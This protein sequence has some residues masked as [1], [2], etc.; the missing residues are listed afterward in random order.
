MSPMLHTALFLL[1]GTQAY[2]AFELCGELQQ[3]IA[4]PPANISSALARTLVLV[5]SGGEMHQRRVR[6]LAC[7]WARR[8]PCWAVVSD[9]CVEGLASVRT[10]SPAEWWA[11]ATGLEDAPP[12][13]LRGR[14]YG[15]AQTR[16]AVG[17]QYAALVTSTPLAV[18]VDTFVF[19]DDDGFVSTRGLAL[20]RPP[21]SGFLAYLCYRNRKFK[22][23]VEVDVPCGG[24]GWAFSATSVARVGPKAPGC[25]YHVGRGLPTNRHQNSHVLAYCLA[26]DYDV[27]G[28]H[29]D[30]LCP[31]GAIE[32][33]SED[34]AIVHLPK[35]LFRK[36]PG[37]GFTLYLG[38][39]LAATDADRSNWQR[40]PV[41]L[42]S[43]QCVPCHAPTGAAG[44]MTL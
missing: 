28:T 33:C 36:R 3:S 16:W 26:R 8:L 20:L 42:D 27:R 29:E 18:P 22:D 24:G 44:S 5:V 17:L 7:T 9:E 41:R 15:A 25:F 6:P 31:D 30:R 4:P 13:S 39:L 35:R 12:P 38:C 23:D 21:Q 2:R 14:G 34:P 40:L 32:D 10:K 19:S 37:V 43:K 1:T 11:E